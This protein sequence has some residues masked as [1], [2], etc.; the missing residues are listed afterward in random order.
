MGSPQL[1]V[2]AWPAFCLCAR[3]GSK[4]LTCIISF[5]QA[6]NNPQ[7]GSVI[8][9]PILW[10]E[11]KAQRGEVTVP[12]SQGSTMMEPGS[13]ELATVLSSYKELNRYLLA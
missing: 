11:S 2:S 8:I 3:H 7:G 4:H 5:N 1:P 6:A 13:K 12:R 10:K 9:I